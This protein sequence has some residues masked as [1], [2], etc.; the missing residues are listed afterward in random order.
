[1]IVELDT[2]RP[3]H[4]FLQPRISGPTVVTYLPMRGNHSFARVAHG[5]RLRVYRN[6]DLQIED[7]LVARPKQ[8]HHPVRGYFAN[9]FRELEIV[10][11]LGAFLLL[12]FDQFGNDVRRVPEKVT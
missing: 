8:R 10:T 11:I 9:R 3:S 7:T 1:M 2:P 5:W 6:I 4:H 12:A